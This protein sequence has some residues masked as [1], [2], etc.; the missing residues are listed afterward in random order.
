MTTGSHLIA[1]GDFWR[2]FRGFAYSAFRLETLQNYAGSGEDEE[3]AAFAAGRPQ[4]PSQDAAEWAA[5]LRAN[6]DAGKTQ[7][8]VHVVVE[9]LTDYLRYELTWAYEA[10]VAAGED[11]RIIPVTGEP[12]PP[13]LPREDYWLF[14][15][16]EL[17]HLHYRQDGTWLGA[18]HIAEPELIV[19]ACRWRD[20]ALHHG[21]S[22]KD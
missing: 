21:I 7:Q 8:R 2:P 22:W 12:W 13:G 10:N 14:D 1:P 20:A 15:S 11:T 5:M 18:E 9:P 19:N 6:R 17:Y 4:P 16:S 3:L